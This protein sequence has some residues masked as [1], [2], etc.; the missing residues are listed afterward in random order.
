MCVWKPQFGE[1]FFFFHFLET[2]ILK[3][4]G[5]LEQYKFNLLAHTC[6]IKPQFCKSYQ[7]GLDRFIANL[8]SPRSETFEFQMCGKTVP[9][10]RNTE[11]NINKNQT[12]ESNI[13]H[14]LRWKFAHNLVCV[15]WFSRSTSFP[16]CTLPTN[17]TSKSLEKS[18]QRSSASARMCS[19]SQTLRS[20]RTHNIF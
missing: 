8:V 18:V 14:W 13:D 6:T 1:V 9:E 20:K 16:H 17:A 3:K 7:T 12:T 2:F 11:W 10:A 15:Y 19:I 4:F 5:A